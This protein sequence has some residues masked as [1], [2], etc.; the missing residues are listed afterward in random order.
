M[1]RVF[2]SLAITLSSGLS[3]AHAEPPKP[4]QPLKPVASIK[5]LAPV[6]QLKPIT[7]AQFGHVF[8]YMPLYVALDAGFLKSKVSTSN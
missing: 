2:I 6:G 5:P 3:A 4:L 7:I 1:K 8:L